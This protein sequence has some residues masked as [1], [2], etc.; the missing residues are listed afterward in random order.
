MLIFFVETT[1]P[2]LALC[3]IGYSMRVWALTAGFHRYFAHRAYK[4]SRVFQFFIGFVGCA[5]LQRGPIW[6][7]GEHRQHHRHSD[8]EG[9][10][11]SPIV[12]S[13]FWSHVGWVL[14]RGN[15]DTDWE[16]MKDWVKYPELRILDR[17]H[18]AP[19]LMWA[20]LCYAVAGWSGMAWGFFLSTVMVYHVTFCVNSV[21]HLFG[22]RRYETT[23]RSRNN[24]IVAILTF[25][26]GWHNNHHH[27]MSSARQGFAWYEVDISYI[28]LRILS[29][30][31][32]VWDLREPTQRALGKN[33]VATTTAAVASTTVLVPTD[34][35][36]PTPTSSDRLSV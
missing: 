4:T 11:H 10:P 21:C 20:G 28:S 8:Q 25:G 26:E 32:I 36:E 2:A 16:G 18:W 6:W 35:L 29:K 33:L 1:W 19:G 12:H 23:D 13:V 24:W 17:F 22:Y 31:G 3:A 34:A 7:A 15:N 27:Y 5:S 14:A 9:D 30:L